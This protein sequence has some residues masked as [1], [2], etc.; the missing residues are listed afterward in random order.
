V[1]IYSAAEI[2]A[3]RK[4][5]VLTNKV[6]D[7]AEGMTKVGQSTLE[8][9][10]E[11]SRFIARNGAK[12]AFL[13]YKGYPATICISVNE[14]VIHGIPLKHKRLRDGQIVSYDV[15]TIL[16]GFFGDAARTLAIGKVPDRA[17][18][19]MKVAR[20]ALYRAIDQ[21]KVGN[22]I[23]DI[24]YAIQ[25]HAESNGF[26]VVKEYVGHCVGRKL[27]EEPQ[28]PNY[29]IRGTGPRIKAGMV[30]AI[31]TM[32]NE[33]TDAIRVLSDNWTVVTLDG[34][35]SAHFEHTLAILSDGPEIL[36]C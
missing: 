19:L 35:L 25:D 7:L 30:M 27:H 22:R 18:K 16:G 2:A 33:G 3:I 31:E 24:S 5:A 17:V 28:I 34:K 11:A 23:G 6:L 13:G 20:E 36:S 32:I 14:E 8:I 4:S 26:S 9:D 29:G 12:P 15:G 21:A 1:N 10:E